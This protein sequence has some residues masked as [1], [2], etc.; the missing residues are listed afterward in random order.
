MEMMLVLAVMVAVAGLA[1]PAI[2]GAMDDQRLRRAGDLV[3][4]EWARARVTA[5]KT[6]RM[7]VFRYEIGSEFYSI[8]PWQTAAD[9]LEASSGTLVQDATAQISATN[10]NN[11][12]GIP[13]VQL[14]SG[15]TFLSGETA[16]DTR[17][18]QAMADTGAMDSTTTGTQ[19]IV[20]YP[21]GSATDARLV[22]TN[23]RC[24]IQLYLRG[25]TGLSRGSDLLTAEEI[26]Q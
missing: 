25:L 26:A 21:D 17:L 22:L 4:A 2:Q 11:P 10:I 1:Y 24:F 6:G 19:P 16:T 9:A 15:M 23:Q 8:R 14:P 7:H 12:L 13:G 20:F 5:M 18:V 3:R